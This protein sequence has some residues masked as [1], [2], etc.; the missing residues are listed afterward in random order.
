MI[1]VAHVPQM[2]KTKTDVKHSVPS[3][4]LP[5]VPSSV[6][7]AVPFV[8]PPTTGGT[9]ATTDI[10]CICKRP[11][12]SRSVFNLTLCDTCLTK[13]LLLKDTDTIIFNKDDVAFINE[14]GTTLWKWD[15]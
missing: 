5:P 8:V 10:C 6:L 4:V 15:K 13:A 14:E 7:F 11:Y 3:P 12:R 2:S 9:Q 1:L